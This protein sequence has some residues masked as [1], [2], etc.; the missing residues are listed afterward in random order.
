MAVVR[1]ERI[2]ILVYQIVPVPMVSFVL[3]LDN[4]SL[5]YVVI[6]DVMVI[7]LN[8]VQPVLR[9]AESAHHLP[10]VDVPL[11]APTRIAAAMVVVT[12]TTAEHVLHRSNVMRAVV[13]IH[14]PAV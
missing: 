7:Q 6:S 1:R 4:A 12:T 11:V 13:V 3:D 5:W 10:P 14:P 2:V 9:I 8:T